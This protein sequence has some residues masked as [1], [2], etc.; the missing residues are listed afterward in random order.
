MSSLQLCCESVFVLWY[1]LN[2]GS[3]MLIPL[4]NL[5]KL[6]AISLISY[7]IYLHLKLVCSHKE[8]KNEKKSPSFSLFKYFPCQLSLQLLSHLG[9]AGS[10]LVCLG[11][12]KSFLFWGPLMAFPIVLRLVTWKPS[13][14][15]RPVVDIVPVFGVSL[16]DGHP[17]SPGACCSGNWEFKK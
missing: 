1:H 3:S 15:L 2:N 12:P 4:M 11:P 5:I 10:G 8:R 7:L 13:N 6:L 9:A 14:H 17:C 16:R